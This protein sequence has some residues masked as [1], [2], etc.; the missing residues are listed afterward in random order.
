MTRTPYAGNRARTY[1]GQTA[2]DPAAPSSGTV[3]QKPAPGSGRTSPPPGATHSGPA[4]RP[5]IQG[6]RALA[7]TLVVL[8]HAGVTRFS[9][10]YVGVDVFF[11]ISGFLITSSLL[12]ELSASDRISIR[13]FYARRALRLLPASALVVL[14]TLAGSWLFLSKV[15]FAEYM[16]DAFASALYAVNFRLAAT[17]TDY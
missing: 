13:A 14:V 3:E 6:L 5:D 1:T 7:V 4:Q 12:R 10:G 15:R 11:V 17:G 8:G 9:G 2:T 16:S